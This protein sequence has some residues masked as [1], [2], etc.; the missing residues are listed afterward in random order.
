MI[1]RMIAALSKA[2]FEL[3]DKEMA[4]ILW[5]AVQMQQSDRSLVNQQKQIQ[6]SLSASPESLSQSSN[7]DSQAFS[8]TSN[9]TSIDVYPQP[10]SDTRQDLTEDSGLPIKVAAAQAL[11]NPLAIARSLKPL[12]RRVPSRTQ[13]VLDEVATVQRIAEEKLLIPVVRPAPERWFEVVLVIDEGASMMLWKQTIKE[14]RQLLEQHGAFRDVRTWGLFTDFRGKVRLHARTVSVARHHR[15]H[16][17]RELIDPSGRRLLLVIS[18]CVS[19]AWRSGAVTEVLSQWACNSPLAI[20]QVLPEWLWER[21]ALG[22]AESVLLRSSIPGVS[23][24]KLAMKALDLL[25]DDVSKGI[26]VPVLTLEPESLGTWARMVAG[27]GDA[28]IKGFL[29]VPSSTKS[30]DSSLS[31]ESSTALLSA[32][33]RLHR[34]RLSASPMARRLAGLLAAAPISLPVVRLIQQTMLPESKQ[35]HIAEVFLGGILKPVSAINTDTDPENIQYDF[36]DEIRDLLLDSVPLTKSI[37][38][39]REVSQYVMERAGLSVNDFTAFLADPTLPINSATGNLLVRPFARFTAQVLKRLGG[40]YTQLAEQLEQQVESSSVISQKLEIPKLNLPKFYKAS[41]PSYALAVA[42]PKDRQYYIDFS[43]VRGSQIVEQ[44][45]RT[46]SR[47]SPD[48][49][50]CQLFTG[51]IG[52]G[53]ST[54]L[55]RLQSELEKQGFYVVYFESSKD[56]DMADVD[57]TDILLSV[58]RQVSESI[59]KIKIKLQLNGF[60]ALLKGMADVFHTQIDLKAEAALTGISRINASTDGNFSLAL[61]IGKITAKAKDAPNLRSQLRQYLE[62][63]TNFILDALNNDLLGPVNQELKRRGKQGLVVI[64]DNLDRI[65]LCASPTGRFQPEYLFVDRGEQLVRLNCH[66]VYTIPL[67]LIFSSDL[68]QLTNRFGVDPMVLRMVPVLFR[69]GSECAES[70]ELLRQMVLARAFPAVEPIARYALIDQIFDSLET[71]DRLCRVSGGHVRN[72]LQLLYSCLQKQDPPL[73][74]ETLENVII[75]RRHQLTLSIEADEWELLRQVVATKTVSGETKYQTLL[76]SLWVFEY[77][78]GED[79]WFDVNPIL[80]D[81]KELQEIEDS[82]Q[83]L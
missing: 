9:D 61:E 40:K 58:A 23:N 3:T 30:D 75:Q 24:S 18:D 1:E 68:G 13:S 5:L 2:G 8:S 83:N 57:I 27:V 80:A 20:I 16:N 82:E 59:E 39:L 38:V 47:L 17:P 28:Q 76:R 44:L 60:K 34:F 67:V 14:F 72:L 25:D 33:Q 22:L 78:Y 4:D 52:C 66:V 55:L 54:E 81:A 29:F 31:T 36:I 21:S 65:H 53:K 51:H 50:T 70:L 73:S 19:P 32:K 37:E 63:R 26:K 79:Y 6:S 43:S 69:D 45:E 49:P 42:N 64:I 77:R 15:F 35:V 56:L 7:E 48:E 11:R 74:R 62:P 46:I 12:K 10:S 71:L 41:N